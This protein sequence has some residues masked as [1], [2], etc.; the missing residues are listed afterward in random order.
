V[1]FDLAIA[2]GVL[3]AAGKVPRSASD[4]VIFVGE[5]TLDGR[6][7]AVPDVLP[8]TMAAQPMTWGASWCPRKALF[9]DGSRCRCHRPRRPSYSA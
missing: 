3:A 1:S 5:L 2:I 4:G 7:R 9:T 8:M 6:L